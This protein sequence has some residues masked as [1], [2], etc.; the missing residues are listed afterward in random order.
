MTTNKYNV[1]YARNKA[2]FLILFVVVALVSYI[3]CFKL[4]SDRL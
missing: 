1:N 2:Y 4:P 3:I